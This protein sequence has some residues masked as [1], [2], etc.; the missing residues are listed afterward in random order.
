M[1]L[2]QKQQRNV[3]FPTYTYT[4]L[5]FLVGIASSN[6]PTVSASTLR[7]NKG[8]SNI[9]FSSTT[10]E[11]VDAEAP[12]STTDSTGNHRSLEASRLPKSKQRHLASTDLDTVQ[13]SCA[14]EHYRYNGGGWIESGKWYCMDTYWS[15][16][17]LGAAAGTPLSESC[18]GYSAYQQSGTER[19][20][21]DTETYSSLSCAERSD[22]GIGTCTNPK[23][24]W[25]EG[26]MWETYGCN[27]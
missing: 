5:V 6:I 16:E 27:T 9:D 15:T 26:F 24:K 7:G 18:V 21:L 2:S 8:S 20:V 23:S 10:N 13:R 19:I 1:N 25:D 3:S 4:F 14:Y 12:I 22:I 11:V 17:M